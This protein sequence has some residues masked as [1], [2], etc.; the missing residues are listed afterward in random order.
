MQKR[1][2]CT[3][4]S[5]DN[6]I[7]S[8]PRS[9][10]FAHTRQFLQFVFFSCN[11]EHKK[12]G[13]WIMKGFQKHSAKIAT[14]QTEVKWQSLKQIT[15]HKLGK[16]SWKSTRMESHEAVPWIKTPFL[17]ATCDQ[18]QGNSTMLLATDRAFGH[19]SFITIN[20]WFKLITTKL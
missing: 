6:L 18:L 12:E 1:E 9:S 5:L 16:I 19:K 7:I 15:A 4:T 14:F 20:D 17:E 10:L 3:T 2:Q 8:L 11:K 13:N